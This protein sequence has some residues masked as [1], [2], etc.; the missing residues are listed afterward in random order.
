MNKLASLIAAAAT[1]VSAANA[2]TSLYDPVRIQTDNLTRTVVVGSVYD[3]RFFGGPE[4]FI[5]CTLSASTR[6]P[7]AGPSDN[8]VAC[9]ARDS[10]GSYYGCTLVNP[11]QPVIDA[12][13]GIS[14]NSTIQYWG[15]RNGECLGINIE[16]GSAY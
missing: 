16:N 13:A 4:D 14:A 3:T 5:L 10:A 15:N 11:P 8:W 12:I 2:G 1:F 7:N 6:I 9:A